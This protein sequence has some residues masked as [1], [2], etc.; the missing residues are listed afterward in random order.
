MQG[1]GTALVGL[2]L[3]AS[4]AGTFTS[5]AAA[6]AAEKE[7][8]FRAKA[9]ELDALKEANATRRRLATTIGTYRSFLAS[10]GADP[11]TGS[12]LFQQQSTIEAFDSAARDLLLR[13]RLRASVARAQGRATSTGLFLQGISGLARTAG[14]GLGVSDRLG[15]GSFPGGSRDAR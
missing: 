6:R 11:F 8:K 5:F 10:R 2:S 3:A 13:G 4:A 12:A 1:L 7:A 9:E 14:L 15:S